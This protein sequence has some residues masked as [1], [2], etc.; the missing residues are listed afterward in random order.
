MVKNVYSLTV[1]V[2]ILL[3]SASLALA[4]GHPA[5]KLQ[6]TGALMTM[7]QNKVVVTPLDKAQLKAG[8]LV[9]YTILAK[10]GGSAAAVAL[11]TVGPIPVK[12][13]YVAGTASHPNGVKLVYSLDGKAFSAQPMVEVKT[14]HGMVKKPADPSQYVALKWIASRALPPK[15]TFSYSY[16]VRVK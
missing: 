5:V 13:Q 2:C 15:G 12:T 11:Q 10:N 3:C 14:D 1:S 6:L 7:E 8:D 9:R 16:E 4:A